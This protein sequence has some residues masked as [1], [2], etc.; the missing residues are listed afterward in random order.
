MVNYQTKTLLK[1]KKKLSIKCI[2]YLQNYL[3]NK[4]ETNI[5][6]LL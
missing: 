3:Y 2:K 4:P 1:I 6:I 5:E